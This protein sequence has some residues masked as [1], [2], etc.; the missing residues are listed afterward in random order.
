MALDH[1][2]QAIQD[3]VLSLQVFEQGVRGGELAAYSNIIR[4]RTAQGYIQKV[5]QACL[6]VGSYNSC[7]ARNAIL[8][9]VTT[10]PNNTGA[11]AC[12][13]EIEDAYLFVGNARINLK[14]A[15]P[16]QILCNTH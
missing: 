14:T 12:P 6:G 1:L 15:T 3:K 2:L 13:F 11:D 10:P 7:L 9:C 8:L 16:A 4:V 5:A